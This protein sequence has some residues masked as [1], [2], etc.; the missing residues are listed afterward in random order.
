MTDTTLNQG[1]DHGD[2]HW[3]KRT[4]AVMLGLGLVATLCVVFTR[5]IAARVPEQRATLEK[6]IAERTG[7][8]VRFENVRFSWGLDGTGAVFTRVELTDPK[9]GRIRVVAPELRVEL[10]TWDLLRHRQLSL[11]HVTLSSPDIDIIGDADESLARPGAGREL[12]ARPVQTRRD[13]AALIRSYLSWAE[14]MPAGRIEVEGARVHLKRRG[15]RIASH[16]FTLSEAVVSRGSSSFNA[17]GTM[18]LSQDV[19]QSLFVSA[20]LEGLTSGSRV[21]GEVRVIARR[22]F[23]E[24]LP[25]SGLAGRGTIDAKLQLRNGLLESGSWQASARDLQMNG[26]AGA[27][28][29]HVTLRGRLSRDARDLLLDF[30]D[31]QL[32]RGAHLERAPGLSA[33]LALAP[34]SIDVVRTSLQAERLPFMATELIAST[35]GPRLEH[36]GLDTAVGWAPTA[37]ELHDVRF[38]SGAGQPGKDG[39]T[40]GARVAGGTLTR[41]VDHAQL[42]QLQGAVHADATGV[43]LTFDSTAEAQLS[44][45]G[46]QEPRAVTLDGKLMLL[47][48]ESAPAWRFA[49]LSVKHEGGVVGADG[50]WGATSGRAATLDLRLTG[51]DRALLRD[52]WTLVSPGAPTPAAF[53]DIEQGRIVEGRLALVSAADGAVNWERSSGKL[54]LAELATAEN[55]T[56]RVAGGRGALN[57]ARGAAQL[58]LE[59]GSVDD[60]ALSSAQ[61]DWPRRGAPRLRVALEG[62]LGSPLIREALN[63]YG[64]DRLGGTVALEAEARGEREL[65]QPQLWR[66][67]AR[68][69]S[70]T[71]P[72]GSGLP[73]AENLAGTIRYSAR[74]LRGLEL[75]GSWLGGPVE[76]ESRRAAAR[77]PLTFAVHGVADAAPLLELSGKADVAQRVNGQLAWSGTVEAGKEIG[78]WQ[79]TLASNLA[80]IESLL[81]EPFDKLRA[82][83]V[84]VTAQLLINDGIR[85]FTVESSDDLSVQGQVRAGVTTARFELRGVSGELRRMARDPANPALQLDVLDFRKAPAVLAAAGALLPEETE[86]TLDI[87]ELR[88]GE[89]SLGA[90]H[91]AIDRQESGLAFSMESSATSPHQMSAHGRCNT[92]GRCSADFSA[93]TVQLASLLHDVQLP[94][95]WPTSSLQASGS[96]AWPAEAGKDVIRSLTGSFDFAAEGE[97]DHQ[98]TAR[99][100]VADGQILLADVQGTGPEP[101]QVFRGNGRIGLVARDYDLTVDYERTVLAAAAVPNPARARLAR[102]WSAVRG[103]VA[104]RGWTEAPDSKRI[105]W[106]GTWD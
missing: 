95:E 103:S 77:G 86:L 4:V 50:A 6:L 15:E 59:A 29:D 41:G 58:K 22:V 53:A 102:A 49:A 63:A 3:V 80:G 44:I 10:D 105:Q 97:R 47:T 101:D 31:L 21:S 56:P 38:D 79:V 39:W 70:G 62:D 76:I 18:L 93:S 48:G 45:P 16:S 8:D 7:L 35:F 40:F 66:V 72:L 99:A 12:R 30:E 27:R 37:G 83:S 73:A 54:S 17:H 100:S 64:L 74:Q 69:R 11:G 90:L 98:L 20:K 61:L 19:G 43:A 106:H 28:F 78:S 96:L 24:R 5:V 46:T 92:D 14:L 84:P 89:S 55:S 36:S 25:A 1:G 26:E 67:T 68:V 57:F 91:A 104:R 94:N 42:A 60:L 34:G 82:R 51:V 65:R 32:T 33:R 81:P 13:E 23:L 85:D 88:Y 52:A 75:K 2:S 87:S 71:V 9:A